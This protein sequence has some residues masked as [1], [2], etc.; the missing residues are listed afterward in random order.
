M[1]KIS[2]KQLS[3]FSILFL[4]AL[5]V[6]GMPMVKTSA[7]EENPLPD[8]GIPVLSLTIDAEEFQKVIDS[9][10]HSYR[11][12]TGTIS[13]DY[14]EGYTNEYSTEVLADTGEL[15]LEYIRGRGNST[16]QLAKKPFK[17]KLDKKNALA[18]MEKTK[19]WVLLA[20][21]ADHTLLN[22]R[23]VGYIA[24]KLGVA[25]PQFV[26]VDFVVN[27]KYLGNYVLAQQVRI[28]NRGLN[29]DELAPEDITAPAI[30]GSYLLGLNPYMNEPEKNTF[31]TSHN[32]NFKLDT[33]QFDSTDSDDTLGAEEQRA[34]IT[35]FLQNLEDAMFS[36]TFTDEG[37]IRYSEYMDLTSAA[38][39]WW[40]QD[41]V[42]NSDG[43]QTPS[44]YFYKTRDTDEAKGKLFC[45]PLWDFDY[46]FTMAVS[47]ENVEGFGHKQMDWLDHMRQFD[48]VYQEELLKAWKELDPIISEITKDDGVL[49]QYAA[50]IEKSWS[51]DYAINKK[52]NQEETTLKEEVA[53]L[54]TFLNGRQ[55]WVNANLDKLFK[56]FCTV[57]FKGEGMEPV[58]QAIRYNEEIFLN[59][60]PTAEFQ[61]DGYIFLGW[62]DEEG[63]PVEQ[64]FP[65]TEDRTFTATY[66]KIEDAVLPDG[67]YPCF[68]DLWL[69]EGT[70]GYTLSDICTI[71][72]EH[73]DDASVAWTSSD[74]SIVEV[75]GKNGIN[76]VG[77]GTATITGTT[78]S[79]VSASITVHVFASET[80][81][82][83]IAGIRFKEAALTLKPGDYGQNIPIL[84]P[85]DV[86]TS[87]QLSF[88][89]ENEA[90]ATVDGNGVVKAIA[91]GTSKILVIDTISGK[92]AS[93]TVTV[94]DATKIKK[95]NPLK[96][97]G[98]TAK[99][100]FKKLKKKAQ[101][102]KV[103]KLIKFAKAGKG[104]IS[105]SLVSAKKGK[106]NVKSYFKINAKTGK[107]TIKK[108][109]A[110][111]TY[112]VKLKVKAA[113]NAD[114]K[115]VTR[116]VT[117]RIKVN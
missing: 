105:Y 43:F 7:E 82:A 59:D 15:A 20:N 111:G 11:A 100:S 117:V 14:P 109:L 88:A 52:E 76:C 35:G 98:K 53:K 90:V 97:K 18:G 93:Y 28:G 23:L 17:I 22:N 96:V 66:I 112:K 65:I 80:E 84:T 13:L 47:P 71:T 85:V 5:L 21:D 27:G 51:A 32:V 77:I 44:T 70:Y 48:P 31:T 57:T 83:T 113:G 19:H 102:L 64:W 39:Y 4:A 91:P 94:K 116:S 25:T 24:E 62:K 38:R 92:E 114:Y 110:K 45:G 79:G 61:K 58:E 49:D 63:N 73:V 8:N 81:P 103:S 41:F 99:V 115:A 107:L 60:F 6:F 29:I 50:E 67:L 1:Q 108:G 26:S 54:K 89:S 101:T 2:C 72:P 68:T 75:E 55:S 78:R 56:V 33:P 12:E 69:P 42:K 104:K 10:D 106:K 36:E 46:A 95:A 87:V 40:V 34:Y 9:N 3:V 30:T 74:D 86:P 16:W 37:G